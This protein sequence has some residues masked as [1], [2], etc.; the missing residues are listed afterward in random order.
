MRYNALLQPACQKP[1][2]LKANYLSCNIFI[3]CPL[4]STLPPVPFLFTIERI[5]YLLMHPSVCIPHECYEVIPIPMR[6]TANSNGSVYACPPSYLLRIHILF[7]PC[8]SFLIPFPPPHLHCSSLPCQLDPGDVCLL[9]G[10][11]A[12]Q[13]ARRLAF[14]AQVD[15]GAGTVIRSWC[16]YDDSIIMQVQL[17]N[18]GAGSVIRSWCR[19]SDSIMVQVQ[20][21]NHGAGVVI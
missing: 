16:R 14:G 17:F 21:I 4:A 5:A 11:G 13:G 8:N 20:L 10:H 1:I 9:F 15:H 7:A 19:Y 18:H 2:V 6:R 3:V 12:C